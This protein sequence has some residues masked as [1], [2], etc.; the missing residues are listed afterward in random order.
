VL[1]AP[2]TSCEV[3]DGEAVC[4][5]DEPPADPVF[6]GGFAGIECPGAGQCLDDASDDC[7][8]DNGGADCGGFC[9]CTGALVLCIQGTL[10]DDDPNVCAC[11]PEEP[12]EPEENPCNLVDCP[13]D[14]PVCEVQGGEAVCVADSAGE[15]PFCGGIAA[16]PCPGAGQCIDDPADD[17][18]PENG[19]ADCGGKCECSGVLLL[20]IE[21][22]V[23]DDDPN[24]CACVPEEPDPC[25]LV[26]CEAGTHC[27]VVD[28]GAACV[29]DENPCNLVDC[30]PDRPVC[31]VRDG[32]AVCV[33][34]EPDPCA[35]VLCRRGRHCEVRD[36][37][38]V[39]VRGHSGPCRPG[40]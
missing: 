33:G 26:R 30:P 7:D 16:F 23:F 39:C 5:P 2:N 22:T 37:E 21:G 3:V 32:E 1:C 20:C 35:E 18:D 14:R 27:E 40:R 8:P 6:C 13:P 4:T 28:G 31:E 38:A 9:D 29:P 36:S 34:S 19:G 11:V 15:A 10:F 17:C 25:A 24:V 12:E